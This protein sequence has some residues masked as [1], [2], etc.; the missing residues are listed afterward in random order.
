MRCRLCPSRKLPIEGEG[1]APCRVMLIGEAPGKTEDRTRDSEGRGRPFHGDAGQ[2]LNEVYLPAA[3]LRR[4]D[5]YVTNAVRCIPD[6]NGSSPSQALVQC[7]VQSHMPGEVALADPEII[8]TLGA[9]AYSAMFPGQPNLE[10]AHGIPVHARYSDV[11]EGTLIPM[12]HPAAALR[13]GRIMSL[14]LADFQSMG[15]YLREGPPPKGSLG[16][17]SS[18][19]SP[20]EVDMAWREFPADPVV[21]LAALDTEVYSLQSLLPYCLSWC[22]QAGYG[23]VVRHDCTEALRRLYYHLNSCRKILLHN[24][25]FDIPVLEN[26]FGARL[27]KHVRVVDTMS[28]AYTIGS[29]PQGLKQLAL[30]L[31]GVHMTDFED[32]VR[33][34]WVERLIW[35][36]SGVQEALKPPSPTTEAPMPGKRPRRPPKPPK[37]GWE[38]TARKV[39]G[40][41]RALHAP[42][43]PDSPLDPWKRWMDWHDSD[44]QIIAERV[45]RLNQQ[46]SWPGV[47]STAMPEMSIALVPWEDVVPYAGADA[48]MTLRIYPILSRMSRRFGKGLGL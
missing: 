5:V 4:Q 14:L 37:T 17:Y 42:M 6:E 33:P 46:G 26:L 38:M 40:L 30:R 16:V 36:L 32:V 8:V 28:M 24:A 15:R 1:P 18:L 23:F 9:V 20:E 11:W 39:A 29:I 47:L 22:T 48:D 31:L 25:P 41:L 10:Q 21:P 3:G 12:Y 2:E 19:S 44:R 45:E 13:S 34:Y 35:W 7:C 27:P 43:D